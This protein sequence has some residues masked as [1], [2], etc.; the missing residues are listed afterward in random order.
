MLFQKS[1]WSLC[2]PNSEQK[3]RVKIELDTFIN[4][5]LSRLQKKYSIIF[6][7]WSVVHSAH[8]DMRSFLAW[9]FRSRFG[10]LSII[11]QKY[12]NLYF[13]NW[14]PK[15]VSKSEII[16]KKKHHCVLQLTQ[17]QFPP[18][19]INN[20]QNNFKHWD[21]NH[22]LAPSK[23]CDWNFAR[24]QAL[25]KIAWKVFYYW[26]TEFVEDKQKS[27]LISVWNQCFL[28]YLFWLNNTHTKSGIIASL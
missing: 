27:S 15:K 22:Y 17:N 25:S 10:R 4:L 28:R 19:L 5:C 23:H 24:C 7:I 26:E 16:E 2:C 9:K 20:Y 21:M 8:Y 6:D 11:L 12:K 13:F 18:N 1:V 14:L 3:E